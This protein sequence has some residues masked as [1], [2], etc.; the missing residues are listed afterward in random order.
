MKFDHFINRS[1]VLIL[2]GLKT[3]GS[4][5]VKMFPGTL[6]NKADSYYL[7]LGEGKSSHRIPEDW[8]EL[9]AEV[10]PELKRLMANCDYQL[11][12][13]AGDILEVGKSFEEFGLE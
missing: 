1:L 12:L 13:T 10:P 5:D 7:D 11:S 2:W 3:D 6:A 8:L 9:I 4:S